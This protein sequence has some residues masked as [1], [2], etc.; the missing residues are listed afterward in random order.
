MPIYIKHFY[1]GY[2]YVFV[3]SIS[4]KKKEGELKFHLNIKFHSI[5]FSFETKK[6]VEYFD[7]KLFP[8]LG[9]INLDERVVRCTK[10]NNLLFH[11]V[12]HF[13]RKGI[14][15]TFRLLVS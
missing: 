4:S 9:E 12:F 2:S 5:K 13:P 14:E 1:I 11:F 8:S 10:V 6:T 15:D 7:I 3:G